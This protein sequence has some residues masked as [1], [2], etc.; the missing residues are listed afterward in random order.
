MVKLFEACK[1][2]PMLL[3]MIVSMTAWAQPTRISGKV[4]SSDDGAPIPGV[5]ILEKGTSNGTITDSEGN[6]SISVQANAAL[7]FSFVG[8]A[9][10]EAFVASRS[11]I[12]IALEPDVTSLTEIVVVGYGQQE[13]K[14]VTG[15]V[16]AVD[17]KAFNRGAIVAP[18]Q[19]IV[20]KVAGV[21]VSA[22]GE[23]GAAANIRI[24]GGTSINASNEPLYVIDGVPVENAG[25]AGSRNPL[26]L[27]NPMDIE[28]FTVLK[29]ASSAAIYGSRAANGVIMITTKKGKTGVP[30]FE[31]S[32]FFSSSSIADRVDVFNADQYRELV[33]S[34]NPSKLSLLQN[35]STNWQNQ[36]YR[37]AFGQGHNF[38]MTGGTEKTTY[39]FSGGYQEQQGIIQTS[40][41]ERTNFALNI[42]QMAFNDNLTID[43]NIKGTHTNDRFNPG[44]IGAAI[45]FAPTQPIYDATSP[46]GGYYEWRNPNGTFDLLAVDNP[47]SSLNQSNEVGSSDRSLGNLQFDYKIPQIEGLRANLNLGYDILR[48]DRKNF[49]PSTLISTAS[50]T[51]RVRIENISRLSKLL[52]FHVNYEKSLKSLDG[53]FDVT[54]G[55]SYQ[56]FQNEYPSLE[57]IRLTTNI[58]GAN[59]PSVAKRVFA[60]NSVEE[61]RLISFF[62]RA[63]VSLRDKYLLT[64]TL[65]RDGST[66]FG[67]EN[68]W[69]I[70]PSAAIA[71]RIMEEDF[72]TGLPNI[73]TDL[74]L[75]AGY[76]VNGNQEIGNY[77]FFPNYDSST[78]TAQYQFGNGF[79]STIRPS[80]YDAALKWEETASLNIG[81]D[82]GVLNGKLSG[83]I[84]YYQKNTSDL[85]FT[86]TV[87]AGSNLSNT[88]LTNVGEI[89]NS[90]VELT[91]N[92]IPIA[93]TNLKW[94]VGFNIAT[95]RNEVV[96]LDGANDNDPDFKGYETGGISGGVGNNIQ[97]NRVGESVN[98]FYVYK[99]K[100]DANGAPLLDGIDHNEDGS[101]N[102]A[103]M[104]E[105]I[106]GNGTVND[107]DRRAYRSPAP[108]F[109][110]GLTSNLSYRN[111]D[112]NFTLRANLGQYVYNNIASDGAYLNRINDIK[113]NNLVTSVLEAPFKTPQYFS[114]Y[115]VEKGSFLRM[116]NMTLGYTF[117]KPA[118]FARVRVYG[119]AQ[120]L[121]LLTEYSGLDPEVTTGGGTPSFGIDNNVYPR[122]RTF[123]LGVTIGF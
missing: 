59:N 16:A 55:Y 121:F 87:P 18:E 11:T 10:Q 89:K 48:G 74:K 43:A 96:A 99:H 4:T 116:D 105:D 67:P 20:G 47:V 22:T 28:S 21:Q 62:G 106:D 79:V 111:F 70:F 49:F 39:R 61:N 120:N 7:V 15:V 45:T 36:I 33:A 35:A 13:K 12:D 122:S 81:L 41:T 90:G 71:W 30:R 42:S 26:N 19:L 88:V 94:D 104:Y 86:V 117:N 115:Y 51:G 44:V 91:L 76:G 68:R 73:F 60:F 37:I 29:D 98:A 23:P 66:R 107:R 32:G 27:I 17:T 34:V 63:N 101:I 2:M 9:S 24:R 92:A 114:D 83:S 118:D 93:T 52:E 38:S 46:W 82:F 95:N 109:L 58:F 6:Y 56:D 65:R 57:G 14:D 78:P 3:L 5:N 53:K 102:L 123:L 50:D 64:A 110:L 25:F 72:M 85:L 40:S 77:R 103:D 97:I 119:T 8:Y 113:P 54:V 1:T 69:G 84:E 80:A 108:K 112:L 31:Y 100:L 75:R